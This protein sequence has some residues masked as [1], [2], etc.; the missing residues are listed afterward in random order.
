VLVEFII[1][2]GALLELDMVDLVVESSDEVVLLL[3][4]DMVLL[5]ELE[6]TTELEDPEPVGPAVVVEL[7]MVKGALLDELEETTELEDP[8]PVGPAVAVELPI[9]KCALLELM[10]E[11]E[12]VI[13]AEVIG[14]LDAVGP[15][16]AVLLF[17]MV[18]RAELEELRREEVVMP[19]VDIAADDVSFWLGNGAL[20]LEDITLE[21]EVVL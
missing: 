4:A 17:P 7:P 5:D 14:A 21:D 10:L 15:V 12:L 6:V 19:P 13:S 1:G 20:L 3:T 9:V 8:V 2:N 18:K 11:L 16:E